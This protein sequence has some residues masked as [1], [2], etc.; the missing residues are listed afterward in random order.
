MS[1]HKAGKFIEIDYDGT[2]C[3]FNW[4]NESLPPRPGMVEM[5]QALDKRGYKIIIFTA[6]A[7]K[8]WGMLERSRQVGEVSR[9]L[10]KY[11]IPFFEI[12]NEKRPSLL[13]YDDRAVNAVDVS[14]EEFL[15][16]VIAEESNG[17]GK[18]K[19]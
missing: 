9:Y 13:I 17:Y 11:K 1:T 3:P 8:G 18:I 7:W 2:I 19:A 5:L 16:R 10:K 12:S 4:P 15:E 6:R 14:P